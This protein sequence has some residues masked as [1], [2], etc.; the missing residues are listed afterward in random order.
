[1]VLL[2]GGCS[3]TPE[4]QETA[5]AFATEE[6]AFAA[7]E[8]TYRAYV[9]AVNDRRADQDPTPA[10]EEFLTGVALQDEIDSA[11][12]L[13]DRGWSIRGENAL[14]ETALVRTEPPY[15]LVAMWACVDVSK[16]TVRDASDTDVTPPD[17][18]ERIPIAIELTLVGTTYLISRTAGADDTKC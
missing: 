12:Q 3:V 16:T 13:R 9:D 4:P 10:P 2:M 14:A 18:I 1:M 5:P 8:Q 15:D 11:R 6:E 7:A 17:R